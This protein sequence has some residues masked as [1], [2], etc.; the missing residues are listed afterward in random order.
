[1]KICNIS[2][3]LNKHEAKGYCKKH[4]RANYYSKNKE[5]I[6]Q[7]S[8]EYGKKNSKTLVE[9]RKSKKAEYYLKNK[10]RI[11]SVNKQYRDTNKDKEKARHIRWANEN[12]E[13]KRE[14]WRRR[15]AV[16]KGNQ[17]ERYTEKQVIEVYGT[18]CYLCSRPIDMLATRRCGQ[19]GWEK[20]LHIEHVVDLALGGPDTLHNVRPAHALCNL[21]KKPRGMV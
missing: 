10:E 13:K 1:M 12:R 9:R 4:Y 16:R 3:C 6:S 5:I 15:E 17:T 18:D 21:R 11:L 7:K 20:G 19:P 14:S 8:R 2:D